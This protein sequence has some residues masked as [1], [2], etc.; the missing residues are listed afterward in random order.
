MKDERVTISIEVPF[1]ITYFKSDDYEDWDKM[2]K[3]IVNQPQEYL[4]DNLDKDDLINSI[5][6][7]KERAKVQVDIIDS[8]EK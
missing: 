2:K 8:S 4:M 1:E 6:A 7:H 3:D 5:T